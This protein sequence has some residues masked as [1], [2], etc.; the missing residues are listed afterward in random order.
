M[1][2]LVETDTGR[3]VPA[4]SELPALL[5][6]ARHALDAAATV[7]EIGRLVDMGQV[8]RVAATRAKLGKASRDD[9]GVCGRVAAS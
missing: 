3:S 8:C 1:T 4:S 5:P 7:A 6:A 2:D 9:W